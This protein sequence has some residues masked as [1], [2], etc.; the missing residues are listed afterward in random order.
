MNQQQKLKRAKEQTLERLKSF[1]NDLDQIGPYKW[2][3]LETIEGDE[4]WVTIDLVAKK[5]F[6]IDAA[7]EEFKDYQEMEAIKQRT[8]E[9][10]KKI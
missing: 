1:V 5:N 9:S 3:S 8:R 6:N 10:K 7:V 2:A 4:I